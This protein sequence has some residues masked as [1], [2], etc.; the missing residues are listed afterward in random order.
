MK[1]VN[2]KRLFQGMPASQ[3]YASPLN[4]KTA[5]QRGRSK[6]MHWGE[7]YAPPGGHFRVEEANPENFAKLVGLTTDKGRNFRI[8][9][10]LGIVKGKGI[11]AGIMGL[12]SAGIAA[13]TVLIA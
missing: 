8:L 3:P 5:L 10:I 2:V 13:L 12:R 7:P 11:T 6:K 9:Q 4:E 1:F